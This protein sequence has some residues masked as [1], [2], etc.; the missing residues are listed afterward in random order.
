MDILELFKTVG[1]IA[2]LVTFAFVVIDRFF[3][4]R[5]LVYLLPETAHLKIVVRNVAKEAIFIKSFKCS[6]P[7]MDVSYG[8]TLHHTINTVAGKT[9][10][11][12]IGP[13]TEQAFVWLTR[14]EWDKLA[15]TDETV[16]EVHWAFTRSR[17]TPQFPVR[18]RNTVE[19]LNKLRESAQFKD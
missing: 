17:W 7:A 18:V 5:P 12:V 11:A 1:S 13:E 14:P 4:D 6:P 16:I 10:S 2:G 3:K 9:F 19:F 15:P 8:P